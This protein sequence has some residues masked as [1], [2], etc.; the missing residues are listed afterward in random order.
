MLAIYTKKNNFLLLD[1]ESSGCISF[2][3][4][5]NGIPAGDNNLCPQKEWFVWI[6]LV[7]YLLLTILLLLNLLIAIFNNTYTRIEDESEMLWKFQRYLVVREYVYKTVLPH[8]LAWI[9]LLCSYIYRKCMSKEIHSGTDTTSQSI[10]N[11]ILFSY[12]GG[13]LDLFV[14]KS[15]LRKSYDGR[16]YLSSIEFLEAYSAI[17]VEEFLTMKTASNKEQL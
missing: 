17:K 2:Q 8:P 12:F 7:I 13:P 10:S 5:I 14:K 6:L 15:D 4:M 1:G 9:S 3:D 11:Y 16:K